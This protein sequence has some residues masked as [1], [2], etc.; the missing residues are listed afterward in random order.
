MAES[1]GPEDD[2]DFVEVVLGKSF[3]WAPSGSLK[4]LS[5]QER[6]IRQYVVTKTTARHAL[7][8]VKRPRI[9]IPMI[10]VSA[11]CAF[12]IH[13]ADGHDLLDSDVAVSEFVHSD[14]D[15]LGMEG[16]EVLGIVLG[17]IIGLAGQ[18]AAQRHSQGSSLVHDMAS[19]LQEAAQITYNHLPLN[20]ETSRVR[21]HWEI[22]RLL[23]LLFVYSCRELM[24]ASL[25]RRMS[26]R[27]SAKVFDLPGLHPREND[28][29]S[30]IGGAS[31][32]Y[33]I[34]GWIV[35]VLERARGERLLNADDVP[36]RSE[37]RLLEFLRKWQDA[38]SL[39]K[40]ELHVY[41][42][43]IIEVLL[44]LFCCTLPFPLV[45]SVGRF[46]FFPALA[47][48][49]AFFALYAAIREMDSPYGY[50]DTDIKLG[51]YCDQ[52]WK[53]LEVMCKASVQADGQQPLLWGRDHA[54][55]SLD[56]LPAGQ[57]ALNK[58]MHGGPPQP[59]LTTPSLQM[60]QG[61]P[62]SLDFLGATPELPPAL[63]RGHS[64]ATLRSYLEA[65]PDSKFVTPLSTPN[66]S[67]CAST[68]HPEAKS[69]AA[70]TYAAQQKL[71]GSSH[72]MK[73][74]PTTNR[75]AR[76]RSGVNAESSRGV[77]AASSR[78]AQV[79]HRPRQ[80]PSIARGWEPERSSQPEGPVEAGGF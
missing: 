45:V 19:I 3:S 60:T 13:F 52:L 14:G 70:P 63:L 18:N 62:Y 46:V 68:K 51:E 57:K 8:L 53:D 32:L 23:H 11:T 61:L 77:T 28:A 1:E 12:A 26:P 79:C 43:I 27:E 16:H 65:T 47:V 30:K 7:E 59:V 4:R 33:V 41:F 2:T 10:I 49:F 40:D 48:T 29:L 67:H 73:R 25:G 34:T 37:D 17:F 55:R 56:S 72:T 54:Q 71:S 76:R 20:A 21:M 35:Q 69:W 80:D 50:D 36:T 42:A 44:Y 58:W 15:T 38:M 78:R 22:S 39:A 66:P 74:I 75:Q 64:G 6:L 31:R 5:I 24:K 9:I